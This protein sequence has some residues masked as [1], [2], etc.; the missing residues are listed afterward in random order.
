MTSVQEG[1]PAV[2]A[3][4]DPRLVKAL[5]WAFP[6]ERLLNEGRHASI[7][8]LAAAERIERGFLMTLLRL[9]LM[10]PA[11]VEAILDRR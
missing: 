2:A 8:E 6:Y 7:S 4:A 1:V 9:T 5:A 11:I 10:A 3:R